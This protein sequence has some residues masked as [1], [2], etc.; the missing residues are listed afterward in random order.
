MAY[1]L[2]VHVVLEGRTREAAERLLKDVI[3]PTVKQQAGF[4]RA[5]WLRAQDGLKGMAV[6]VFDSAE[7]AQSMREAMGTVRPADAPPI[8][9]S[10][11]FQVTRRLCP[12]AGR[13]H[14]CPSPALRLPALS[15]IQREPH[16]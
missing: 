1:A 10:E 11:I 12:I 2:V 3:V 4:R 15:Q 8:T 16:F 6:I 14:E 7:N 13:R 9:G 5:V